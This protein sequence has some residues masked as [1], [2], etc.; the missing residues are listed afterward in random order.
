MLG[1]SYN[2]MVDK[3]IEK[4][5][6]QIMEYMQQGIPRETAIEMVRQDSTLN[7]E[8]WDEV[9]EIVPMEGK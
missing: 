1:R 9:I 8:A 7:A 6:Y 2:E 4:R 5:A 3:F